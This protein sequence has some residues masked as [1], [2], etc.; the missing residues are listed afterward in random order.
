MPIVLAGVW[1]VVFLALLDGARPVRE[2][3]LAGF[4]AVCVAVLVFTETL[5]RVHLLSFAWL[6]A[7]W[8]V[9]LCV[10]CAMLRRRIVAGVAG[11]GS[12]LPRGWGFWDWVESA[13]RSPAEPPDST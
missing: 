7:S 3:A 4:T 5:S 1:A 11:L 2:S 9:L 12:L 10:L 13:G 6:A 8:V